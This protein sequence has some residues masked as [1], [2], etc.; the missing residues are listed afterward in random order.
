MNAR[1]ATLA[2]LIVA[3]TSFGQTVTIDPSV[4]YQTID[5][6]GYC[7]LPA[8]W[9]IKQGPFYY[10]APF[11]PLADTLVREMGLTMMRGFDVTS[12]EFCPSA[13][14]YE[15]TSAIRTYLQR[16]QT[17]Q[18]VADSLGEVVRYSPNVFSP[19]GWMKVNGQCNGAGASTY[20]GSNTLAA[21]H[22]NDF[23]AMCARYIQIARDSFDVAVY[24]FS[25]Q[26]EP[27]FN[28][29]YA[30]CSYADGSMYAQVLSV[31]GPA[32]RALGYGTL[33]YG[34]EHM[35]WAYPSWETALMQNAT[36]RQYL[37]RFA[38]HSFVDGVMVDTATFDSFPD[39][40]ARPWWDSEQGA[41]RLSAYADAFSEARS[42]IKVLTRCGGSAIMWGGYFWD[43][44]TGAK[45]P[46]FYA[47]AQFMRFVRP[48]MKRI[49]ATSSSGQIE[50]GAYA[51]ASV[52]SMSVVLVNSG[53]S[54]ISVTL[55]AAGGSLPAQFE[56]RVTSPSQNFVDAGTVSSGAAI[57]VPATGIVSLGYRNR[58][59]TSVAAPALSRTAV[60]PSVVS[61][62]AAVRAYDLAGRRVVAS[63]VHAPGVRC[64]TRASAGAPCT[65]SALTILTR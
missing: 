22:Y 40:H 55:Q 21:S 57:S 15:I 5:G 54:A 23:A 41:D 1:A 65:R 56:M 48:G 30:S 34:C 18:H 2:A 43:I 38:T 51:D 25:L 36:A 60:A 49:K 12:C 46:R 64:V 16:I 53:A 20:D 33:I 61:T 29:P 26:N 45:D 6:L 39:T 37:D 4:N 19:P 42:N 28:E 13:G 24:A 7:G 9:K 50:A 10:D 44:T 58:G 47:T 11:A 32:I 14:T 17:L 63:P 52:G 31:V 3:A 62:R 27:Y 59:V 35:A 8:M